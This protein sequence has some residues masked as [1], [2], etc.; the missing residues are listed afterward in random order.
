MPTCGLSM[1]GVHGKLAA[2]SESGVVNLFDTN[3]DFSSNQ[4]K[5]HPFF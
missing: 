5:R 3:N 4:K 1:S 2:A